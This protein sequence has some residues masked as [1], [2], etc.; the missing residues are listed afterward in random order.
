MTVFTDVMVIQ[1]KE[2]PIVM[3]A[4]PYPYIQIKHR[5]LRSL[6]LSFFQVSVGTCIV[7]IALAVHCV[8]AKKSTTL[9][10]LVRVLP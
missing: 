5:S 9:Q 1:E 10:V 2:L 7:I 3:E 4:H 8:E 6:N